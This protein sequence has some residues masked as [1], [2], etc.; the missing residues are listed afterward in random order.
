MYS[1][2]ES[3]KDYVRKVLNEGHYTF[4]DGKQIIES[5]GN[6]IRV[7]NPL[8]YDHKAKY[9]LIKSGEVLQD[10]ENGVYDMKNNPI[11]GNSVAIY[12]QDFVLNN[13][14]GFVYTYPD[15]IKT[16]F[17]IDQFQVMVD[18]LMEDLG[19]NRSVAITL[20]PK[21]DSSQNDIPCLQIIQAIVRDRKLVLHV[22]FRS[23]DVF[24]AYYSNMYFLTYIGLLLVEELNRKD[25]VNANIVFDG[26]MYYCS[27]G[28]VYESDLKQAERLVKG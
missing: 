23:N 7:D 22:Y 3:Y 12:M 15:R 18:R 9:Q 14:S 6:M 26:L 2:N 20:D 25:P 28:H 11:K 21:T 27:S 5:L 19:S 17:G 13:K 10:I 24:G 8:G 1:I 16:H 4:K